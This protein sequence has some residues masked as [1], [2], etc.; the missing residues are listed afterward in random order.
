MNTMTYK[1]YA[2]SIEYSDDDECFI[3]HIAGIKDRVGF[4]GE[5]VIELKEA[6]HDAVED[7][8]E[9]CTAVGKD[10]QKP[11]SGK[12]MLRIPPEL[13]ATIATA[14]QVSGQSINQWILRA[15]IQASQV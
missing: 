10:P 5:S 9:T 4:H 14:A 13:H 3:G 11:Y 1:G 8:L 7:Y 15:L 6:F 2:A 12:L